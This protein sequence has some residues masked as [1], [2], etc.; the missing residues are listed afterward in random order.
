MHRCIRQ[1]NICFVP[2][3]T[4]KGLFL[5]FSA[6]NLLKQ[7]ASREPGRSNIPTFCTGFPTFIIIVGLQTRFRRTDLLVDDKCLNR[8]PVQMLNYVIKS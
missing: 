7:V 4:C 3:L 8:P 5:V 2:I 6:Q 1:L